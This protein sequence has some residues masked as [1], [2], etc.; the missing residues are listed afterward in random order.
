MEKPMFPKDLS[1]LQGLKI[2]CLSRGV[3][4][5][6]E[7]RNLISQGGEIPLSIHEYATTGGVTLEIDGGVFVNA[8]FD[9]DYC[10]PEAILGVDDSKDHFEIKFQGHYFAARVLP[11]PGYLNKIDSQGNLAI[12][13]TMSHADR[14]RLSPIEGCAYSCKFCDFVGKKYIRKPVDQILEGFDIAC[15]DTILLVK[16]AL[17][18]GG[19]PS[20]LHYD[21]LDD[22]FE[23]VIKHRSIPVDVMLAP[24]RNGND[25][26]DRLAEWGVNGYSINIEVF[27]DEIAHKITPQKYALGH[28]AYA[29]AIE[30]AVGH[31]GKTGKVRS[32]ILVGLE[33]EEST[34]EGVRFL[35]ELGCDPVLSP[36][37]PAVG[38]P[39][40]NL[41]PPS[42]DM[43]TSVF[44]KSRDIV[45]KYGVKLG[46]RCIPCQHNTLTFPDGTSAYYFS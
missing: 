4:I 21:Y 8:P 27:D 43:L 3:F 29:D 2:S 1:S 45:E 9:E 42:L 30:R 33:P 16:H 13:T 37:R 11:L 35:A 17:I 18:S 26:I 28:S 34:L 46:P 12:D 44:L 24:R 19:T 32:L 7:A 15:K 20:P 31:L 5:T 6:S 36:F 14:V 39:L 23:Q 38:T 40:A 10:D 25:I 41:M 22:V